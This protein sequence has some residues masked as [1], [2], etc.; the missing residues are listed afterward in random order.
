M[1]EGSA[2]LFGVNAT[3][4]PGEV[5][6]PL[7][8]CDECSCRRFFMLSCTHCSISRLVLAC[9]AGL[10]LVTSSAVLLAEDKGMAPPAMAGG[11]H[12]MMAGDRG[13]AD[14]MAATKQAMATDAGKAEMTAALARTMVMEKLAAQMCS[15]EKC[16]AACKNDPAMVKMMADAKAMAADSAKMGMIRDEIMK[17]PAMTR[18]VML[19]AMAHMSM[20]APAM[21]GNMSGG[22]HMMGGDHNM[23]ATTKPAGEMK[24]G[25]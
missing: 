17:D 2:G 3:I 15:D 16:V 6:G 5:S 8:D 19:T 20:M 14:V 12:G 24:P 10:A 22:D 1:N 9:T 4:G 11:D 23:G 25:M 13:M 7:I 18:Q 21:G